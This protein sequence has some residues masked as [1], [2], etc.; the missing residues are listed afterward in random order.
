M[1]SFKSESLRSLLTSQGPRLTDN[2]SLLA[3]HV[4]IRRSFELISLYLAPY[5]SLNL[6]LGPFTF[7]SKTAPDG[8]KSTGEAPKR[9]ILPSHP[10]NIITRASTL[11]GD[12]LSE[13]SPTENVVSVGAFVREHCASLFRR[14]EPT[15]WLRR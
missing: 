7:D 1:V 2:D 12:T 5:H 4:L 15:W 3:E 8:D 13:K 9:L 6:F 10:Q 14:W 11:P